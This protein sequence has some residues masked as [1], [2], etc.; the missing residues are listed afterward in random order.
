MLNA[1]LIQ[2]AATALDL[3]ATARTVV[4]LFSLAHPAMTLADGYAVQAAWAALR[5]ARGERLAGYKIGLTSRAMQ[6]ALK[7]DE[8]QYGRLFDAMMFGDN[9]RIETVRFFKPRIE[10]ELAF[11]LG[12]D[13]AG[14]GVTP[15]AALRGT[16]F[17][18]PALELVD[19]RTVTPRPVADMVADNTAAAGAILGGRR[20]APSEIDVRWVGATLARNGTI[21]ESG[22]SA[23][24]LGHPAVAV[25]KLANMLAAEGLSLRKGDLILAG[26]FTRQIE[27]AAGDT[28]VADYGPLGTITTAFV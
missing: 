5:M 7:V 20:A 2:A 23:A 25:A 22:V 9:A 28:I 14:P 6:L 17:I 1:S 24:V 18:Q 26:S 16:A 13:L 3:A 11:I 12:A 8:P 4:P 10:V 27:V 21:E 19:Y 15:E